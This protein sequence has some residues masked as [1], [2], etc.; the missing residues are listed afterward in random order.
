MK[1]DEKLGVSV[2]IPAYNGESTLEMCVAS[3]LEQDYE[4]PLEIIVVDDCSKDS[5]PNIAERIGAE[6]IKHS[7]NMG[8]AASINDG[9]R[10]ARFHLVLILH[11][12]CILTSKKWLPTMV[13][14][15]L[16]DNTIGVVS[17][18]TFIPEH[19]FNSYSIWEKVRVSWLHE[20]VPKMSHYKELNHDIFDKCDLFKKKVFED[21]GFFDNKHY[22]TFME[23][24]DMSV[25]LRHA[26]YGILYVNIP[27]EHWDGWRKGYGFSR[28]IRKMYEANR[29]RE[30][31]GEEED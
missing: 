28:S 2:I 10:N 3:V 22:R 5:T 27:V 26:N 18:P 8:L 21:I 14:E 30:F 11:Q 19:V 31:A 20:K 1:Y 13:S 24:S 12:D 17:S 23:D 4:G 15:L 9:I 6:V 25:R 16:S 7:R 29:H